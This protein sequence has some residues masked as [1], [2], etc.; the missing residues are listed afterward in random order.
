MIAMLRFAARFFT[1]AAPAEEAVQDTWIDLIAGVA[2]FEGRSPAKELDL[3]DHCQQG[4]PKP[5]GRP[6]V[7]LLEP[8]IL[9]RAVGR[10]RTVHSGGLLEQSPPLWSDIT[11]ERIVV[12]HV[13]LVYAQ[14]LSR[15]DRR[16]NGRS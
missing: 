11:P 12:G 7:A 4:A 9:S 10:T 5:D 1:M 6:H 13:V 14:P 15:H 3:R 8:R 2:R 16:P